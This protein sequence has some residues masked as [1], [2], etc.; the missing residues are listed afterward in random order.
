[1]VITYILNNSRVR[2]I[3]Y[4]LSN[5]RVWFEPIVYDSCRHK[6]ID[7]SAT[8]S[9]LSMVDDKYLHWTDRLKLVGGLRLIDT[10]Q[11]GVG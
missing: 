8:K 10:G 2:I 5:S 4:S 9:E 6:Y 1:M 7:L 11:F 3:A